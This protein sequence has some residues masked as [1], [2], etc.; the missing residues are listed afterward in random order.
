[1]GEI[2]AEMRAGDVS[3]GQCKCRQILDVNV[4]QPV[5]TSKVSLR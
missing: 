2:E 4:P 5:W 3:F 1:M